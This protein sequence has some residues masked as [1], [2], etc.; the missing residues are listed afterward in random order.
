MKRHPALIPLS[1]QHH[2]GLAL[3]VF[4][5]RG[6]GDGADPGEAERLRGKVLDAWNLELRGH[7][8]VEE[9]IL[10]PAVRGAIPNPG[11]VDRLLAEHSEIR[12][13]IAS[14]AELEGDGLAAGLR[15]LGELL[16][17]HI[18]TEERALFEAV[19]ASLGDG[20]LAAL[21]ERIEQALPAMCL[22][23]GSAA[24]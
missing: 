13:M 7:F 23:L 8:E 21:G 9:S 19:Q 17:R 12:A 24:A 11:T 16:T 5:K 14:L 15:S 20:E 10:F 2:D 4:I 18:R 22:D 1:R 6:L 3:G